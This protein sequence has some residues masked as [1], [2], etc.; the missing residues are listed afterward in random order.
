MFCIRLKTGPPLDDIFILGGKLVALQG[1]YASF[2]FYKDNKHVIL[3]VLRF[4]H[5]DSPASGAVW[6][7]L[8]QRSQSGM[9]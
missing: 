4:S 7:P 9:F 6:G 1:L 5:W 8:L 2:F 3:T